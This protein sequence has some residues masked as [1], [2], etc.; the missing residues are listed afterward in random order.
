MKTLTA[1]RQKLGAWLK[2]VLRGEDIG[3]MIDGEIIRCAPQTLEVLPS[4]LDV[5]V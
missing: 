3:V 4:A 2:R 5:M 1:A